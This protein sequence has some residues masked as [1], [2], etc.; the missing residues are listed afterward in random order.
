MTFN[1]RTA[2]LFAIVTAPVATLATAAPANADPRLAQVLASFQ[3]TDTNQDK[4]LD[5]GEF[6][7]IIDRDADDGLGRVGMISRFGLHSR[8]FGRID[9]IMAMAS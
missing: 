5:F 9:A 2:T 4:K 3:Q 1:P 7:T 8:A 6:I